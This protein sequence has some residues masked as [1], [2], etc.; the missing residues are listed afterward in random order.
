MAIPIFF[1]A[2]S[3]G[4]LW[5]WKKVQQCCHFTIFSS[6]S[7]SCFDLRKEKVNFRINSLLRMA[8]ISIVLP[9]AL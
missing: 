2:G 1:K 4:S 9:G 8:E 7:E 3:S 5:F 6:S